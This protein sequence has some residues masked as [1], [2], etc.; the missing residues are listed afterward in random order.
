MVAYKRGSRAYS[1]SVIDHS[2]NA[3]NRRR[4]KQ[5]RE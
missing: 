2:I 1:L 5:A 3:A 4:R